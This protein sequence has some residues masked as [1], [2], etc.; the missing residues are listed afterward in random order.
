MS[1]LILGVGGYAVYIGSATQA[2][3][4]NK[5]SL[6]LKMHA[7]KD[8][9][10]TNLYRSSAF[11]PILTRQFYYQCLDHKGFPVNIVQDSDTPSSLSTLNNEVNATL[12]QCRKDQRDKGE[13]AYCYT[14]D[15]QCSDGTQFILII[16]PHS[17]LDNTD[18][19]LRRDRYTLKVL[20]IN[21]RTKHVDLALRTKIFK[22]SDGD[23]PGRGS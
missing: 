9:A 7:I 5:R 4:A 8:T 11:Y 17:G 23:F 13:P 15:F 22:N 16:N 3:T 1:M 12:A 18:D 2:A 6:Y 19:A 14:H 21:R 20:A 10:I